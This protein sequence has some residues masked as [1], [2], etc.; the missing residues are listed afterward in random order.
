[1]RAR[2]LRDAQHNVSSPSPLP[3]LSNFRTQ[4]ARDFAQQIN[5]QMSTRRLSSWLLATDCTHED[6]LTV[7][8]KAAAHRVDRDSL[9]AD[10]DEV[11]KAVLDMWL[12]VGSDFFVGTRGRCAMSS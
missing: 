9:F 2:S 5:D 11:A 4:T 1:M 12:C 10:E 7:L 6:E 8:K 3:L